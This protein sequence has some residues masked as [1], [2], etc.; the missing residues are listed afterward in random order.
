LFATLWARFKKRPAPVRAKEEKHMDLYGFLALLRK[1]G[2]TVTLADG[3]LRLHWPRTDLPVPPEVCGGWEMFRGQ[4]H[5]HMIAVNRL[6]QLCGIYL[7]WL[8]TVCRSWHQK[9][10]REGEQHVQ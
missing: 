2:A 10:H 1:R 8:V 6:T 9:L 5:W 7:E 4:L 3:Q